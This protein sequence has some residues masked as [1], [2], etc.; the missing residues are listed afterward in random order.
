MKSLVLP[1]GRFAQYVM[2]LHIL[3]QTSVGKSTKQLQ[4]FVVDEIGG[5]LLLIEYKINHLTTCED[6][7][8]R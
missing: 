3:R 6:V 2:Q 5:F 4:I 1:L 7:Y 8:A